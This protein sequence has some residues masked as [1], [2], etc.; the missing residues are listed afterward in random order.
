MDPTEKRPSPPPPPPPPPL[1]APAQEHAAWAGAAYVGGNYEAIRDH[2][3]QLW[4]RIKQDEKHASDAGVA[5]DRQRNELAAWGEC[6]RLAMAAA[7]EMQLIRTYARV[8]RTR[9]L[10]LFTLANY[11]NGIALLLQSDPFAA[12]ENYG[13][14]FLIPDEDAALIGQAFEQMQYLIKDDWPGLGFATEELCHRILHERQ[15]LIAFLRGQWSRALDHYGAALKII[16]GDDDS[17]RRSRAK[18]EG[19]MICCRWHLPDTDREVLRAEMEALAKRCR[20]F[21][22]NVLRLAEEN[23]ARMQRDAQ[24]LL[25]FETI[26]PEQSVHVAEIIGRHA[27]TMDFRSNP[28]EH[29]FTTY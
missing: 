2:V 25:P 18:V 28:A 11:T 15:G 10:A 1:D 4:E 8:W 5:D 3:D 6:C 27:Q 13:T 12:L 7:V 24:N 14:L 19:S 21:G 22:G 26:W 17:A 9:A 16:G 23:R 29:E 20:A